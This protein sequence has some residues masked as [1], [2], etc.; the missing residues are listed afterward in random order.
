MVQDNALVIMKKL[1]EVLNQTLT[2]PDIRDRQNVK[3]IHNQGKAIYQYLCT[4]AKQTYKNG[5][6]IEFIES[7]E[8]YNRFSKNSF[9]STK[10]D[11]NPINLDR[12]S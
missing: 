2:I 10:K 5:F 11:F 7:T 6:E 1:M 3:T 9:V 4:E 12:L 8:N